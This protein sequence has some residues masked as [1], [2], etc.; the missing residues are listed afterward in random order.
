MLVPLQLLLLVFV[1][2][3]D[4]ARDSVGA[5]FYGELSQAGQRATPPAATRPMLG[6]AAPGGAGTG[7]AEAGAAGGGAAGHVGDERPVVEVPPG[8]PCDLTGRWLLTMHKV[9]EALGNQQTGHTYVYYELKQQGDTVTVEK[10]VMCGLDALSEGSFA[11]TVDFSAA[12]PGIRKNVQLAGRK[13]TS[14]MT[15]TGC[16]VDIA[17]EYSVLGATVPHYLDPTHALP[18]AEEMAAAGRP[19]WE[20]WDG[21]GQ[22]GI[23]GTCAGTVTGKIFSAVREWSSLSGVVPDVRSRFTLPLSWDSEP[24]IMAFDGSPFLGSSAV[25][26]ADPAL[27]FAQLARLQPTEAVGD[28]ATICSEV[29]ALAPTLTPEAAGM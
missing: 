10:G 24:N 4:Y 21:D 2:A 19:G 29:I 3:C 5:G 9:T 13:G 26:A 12:W 20:D 1:A 17:R 18:T 15:P 11:V 16:R 6:S 23:T 28:D 14:V 8:A 25:R 7:A 27:H 22:P